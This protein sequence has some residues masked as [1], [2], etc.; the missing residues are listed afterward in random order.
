MIPPQG[1]HDLCITYTL[2]TIAANLRAA[3]VNYF[4]DFFPKFL[5]KWILNVRRKSPKAQCDSLIARLRYTYQPIY[6]L[7]FQ[8]FNQNNWFPSFFRYWVFKSRWKWI[9]WRG[10]GLSQV[11]WRSCEK[12]FKGLFA[13]RWHSCHSCGSRRGLS[14]SKGANPQNSRKINRKIGVGRIWTWYGSR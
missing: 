13:S 10:S 7:D 3:A 1:S 8:I 11:P 9:W 12:A 5:S 6:Y 2:N 14:L 4:A